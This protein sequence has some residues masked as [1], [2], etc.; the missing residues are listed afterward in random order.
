MK[1]TGGKQNRLP[2]RIT[3]LGLDDLRFPGLTEKELD[4]VLRV[5]QNLVDGQLSKFYFFSL[6]NYSVSGGL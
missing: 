5:V 3:N 6:N 2:F 4:W 1:S